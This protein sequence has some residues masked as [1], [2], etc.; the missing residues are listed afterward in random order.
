MCVLP[1]GHPGKHENQAMNC[2]LLRWD[3]PT[4]DDR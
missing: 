2:P 1:K 4:E 3:T